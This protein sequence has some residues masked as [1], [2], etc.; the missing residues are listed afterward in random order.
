LLAITFFL[1]SFIVLSIQP[2]LWLPTINEKWRKSD[3][4]RWKL[5]DY[6]E[7]TTRATFHNFSSFWISPFPPI[8]FFQCVPSFHSKIFYSL[9]L[10]YFIFNLFSFFESLSFDNFIFVFRFV[11]FC[12]PLLNIIWSFSNSSLTTT[13]IQS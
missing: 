3:L 11:E 2:L 5:P 9:L 10:M 12:Y 13:N 6:W 4:S 7:W 1:A 8:H